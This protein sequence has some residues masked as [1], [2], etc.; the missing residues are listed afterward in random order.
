MRT[1]VASWLALSAGMLFTGCAAHSTRDALGAPETVLVAARCQAPMQM[2]GRLD[3]PVWRRARGYPLRRISAKGVR[4]PVEGG[5]IRLAWDETHLYLAAELADSDVVAEGSTDQEAHWQKGDVIELF[6]APAAHTWYWELHATPH[7]HK[8]SYW[9]PG[10]GRLG[11]PSS[12][13]YRC[14]L[15]VGAQ[16]DGT[17]NRWQDRDR[18]WT[19]EMAMPRADLTARG[20]T[21]ADQAVWRV[22]VGRYNYSRYLRRCE[23]SMVPALSREDFHLLG[24]YGRLVLGQERE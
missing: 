19:V 1:A 20:E 4:A 18:G 3:E 6:L 12:V 10:P 17:R 11:V 22:F 14:G 8:T 2:D 15:T 7:G 13:A 5:V 9:F 21:F 23:L 24:E 16:V